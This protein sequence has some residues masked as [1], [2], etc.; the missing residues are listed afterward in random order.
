MTT[1]PKLPEGLE[2]RPTNA[3]LVPASELRKLQ[4]DSAR[5]R[6]LRRGQHW[7][8]IDGMG[9]TLRAEQ[10]DAAIDSALLAEKEAK[11]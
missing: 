5:Y 4:E 2:P 3:V 8:V 10:I 9:Y 1:A 6:L 7:S 11:Q